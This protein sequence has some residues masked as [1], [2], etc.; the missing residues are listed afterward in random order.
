MVDT[1]RKTQWKAVHKELVIAALRRFGGVFRALSRICWGCGVRKTA[2][3]WL[4]SNWAQFYCTISL[5]PRAKSI[6]EQYGKGTV[7]ISYCGECMEKEFISD[8]RQY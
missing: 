8:R 7:E 3:V 1:N 4:I 2:M 6:H 5:A